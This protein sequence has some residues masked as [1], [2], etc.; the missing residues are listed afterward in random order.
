[1][2]STQAT[3]HYEH[4]IEH[5]GFEVELCVLYIVQPFLTNIQFGGNW[6]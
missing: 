6:N 5:K 3:Y 4:F 2:V 1:M